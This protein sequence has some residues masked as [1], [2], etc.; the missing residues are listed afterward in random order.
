MFDHEE[1]Q[2][3]YH[4]WKYA[5]TKDTNTLEKGDFTT[6]QLGIHCHDDTSNPNNDENTTK[7][8][9]WLTSFC[10]HTHTSIE[11]NNQ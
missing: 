6:E 4:Q 11:Y 2:R 3:A 5:V 9:T 8:Y 7:H 10:I 1:Q